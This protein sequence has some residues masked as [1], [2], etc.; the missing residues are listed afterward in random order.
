MRIVRQWWIRYVPKERNLIVDCLAKL[1]LEW[2]TSLQIFEYALKKIL[3]F[4]QQDK[5]ND[6]FAQV[7]L[8]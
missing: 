3:R 8:M 7:N 4:L 6:T 1:S 2:K 5:S